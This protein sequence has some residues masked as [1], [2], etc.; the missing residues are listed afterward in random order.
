M[1]LNDIDSIPSGLKELDSLIQGEDIEVIFFNAARVEP[2]DPFSASAKVLE[3]DFR[4][5]IF[6]LV[7]SNTIILRNNANANNIKTTTLSLYIIAQHYAPRLTALAKSNSQLKPALLVTNSYLPWNPVPL[8]IS[9]SLVKASQ[10]NLIQNIS[11][12]FP[13]SGVHF[14]LIN[15]E[16]I[17]NTENKVL[18]PRTIAQRAVAFW[19]GGVKSGLDC[20]IKEE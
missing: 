17:V 3:E 10:R 15:A 8:Y 5:S 11:R 13:D 6:S 18:N 2:C 14:A 20:S 16:G 9:L 12:A 19:E 1:D 7:T 4:V